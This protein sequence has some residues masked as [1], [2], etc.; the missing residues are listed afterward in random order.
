MP[1]TTVSPL[2]TGLSFR[3]QPSQ[4]DALRRHRLADDEPIAQ[5]VNRQLRRLSK[6]I[7]DKNAPSKLRG[8]G[9]GG[10]EPFR[11]MIEQSTPGGLV[12]G[13]RR[14]M[15]IDKPQDAL[16]HLLIWANDLPHQKS[17][18][19]DQDLCEA[20]QSKW[21][22][23]DTILI[24]DVIRFAYDRCTISQVKS[25]LWSLA[26]DGYVKLRVPAKSLTDGTVVRLPDGR[27]KLYAF[28]EMV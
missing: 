3:L 26:E 24:H 9:R 6:A 20:L 19:S 8:V 1:L 16:R 18:S 13:F 14:E 2:G 12:E 4:A 27:G 25:W 17:F 7:E 22:S 23:G 11:V 21:T 5:V 10:S 15:K 28:V